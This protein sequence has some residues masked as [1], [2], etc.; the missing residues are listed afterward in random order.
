MISSIVDQQDVIVYGVQVPGMEGR[1]GMA[2]IA[3]P[4]GGLDL[5][6]FESGIQQRLPP[7]SRPVFLRLAKSLEV[8]GTFK[9]KKTH[10]Q[11][12]GFDPSTIKVYDMLLHQTY[13]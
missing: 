9:L 13:K 12:E 1:A 3:E 10:L 2:A 5:K 7:Y 8:T 6:S 4:T 11:K